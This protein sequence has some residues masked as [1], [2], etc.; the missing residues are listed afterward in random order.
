[1][2]RKRILAVLTSTVLCLSV[3]AGCGNGDAEGANGTNDSETIS[4][5]LDVSSEEP[6]S[7]SASEPEVSASTDPLEMITE[8]YY[9]Y[10]YPVDGMDDMCAFFHFYEEQPVLGSVFYASFAWN[11]IT[12]VGTYTV[13]EKE[14]A[15]KCIANRDDQTAEPT[16]YTEGTAPYTVTFYDF[17]GNELGA[18]GFDGEILYNDTAI[19]GTGVTECMM[20][21]DADPASEYMA[22][23]EGEVGVAYLDFVAEDPTST[24]TLYHNG[25]YMDLVNMLVEGTWSMAEGAD[26]YEYTL[27]PDSDSDTGAVVAVATDEQTCVYTPGDGECNHDEQREFRS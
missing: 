22:T 17:A 20:Y 11:Q 24:L 5:N 2:N 16:V 25:R 21:H 4:E 13:E 14:S 12:Y 15:Y 23:Y 19:G 9:S 10:T 6:E 1:M 8:G 26:G 3:L 7:E 27:T 18:C